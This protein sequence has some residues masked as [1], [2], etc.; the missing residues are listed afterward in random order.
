MHRISVIIPAF[1]AEPFLDEALRSIFGQTLQPFEVIV[2]DDGSTDGTSQVTQRFT[3][4]RLFR[5]DHRGGSA[6]LNFG[7][8]QARGE[9]IAFLDAD[10]LWHASKLEIQMRW[11]QENQRVEAV[12]AHVITFKD[13]SAI[14][15]L[16][17]SGVSNQSGVPGVM[18]SALLIHRTAFDRV[19]LFDENL[20]IADFPHWYSRAIAIG[21]RATVLKDVLAFRRV[22]TRNTTFMNK[23][24]LHADYLRIA[25]E[26]IFRRRS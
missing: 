23:S 22:H 12:F 14:T 25:R 17:Q 19:G 16:S 1:N 4:V 7:L 2:V 24:E 8:R 10:D 3:K 26:A 5:R 6:S 18:K 15:P 11:L 20:A 9:L 21:L 13:S